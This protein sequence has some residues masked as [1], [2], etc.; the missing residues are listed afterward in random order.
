MLSE[1]L[2]ENLDGMF[3]DDL[4]N[5]A[6]KIRALSL[7]DEDSDTRDILADYAVNK[8]KAM[9]A[10]GKGDINEALRIERYCDTLYDVLPDY[11]QW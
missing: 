6:N 1:E 11:A 8:A 7:T 9:C 4:I 3:P 5:Y 2:L 10:R